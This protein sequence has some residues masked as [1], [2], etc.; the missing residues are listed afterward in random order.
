VT[1]L[2]LPGSA[3]HC[4]S[5]LPFS[6]FVLLLFAVISA[7]GMRFEFKHSFRP[8]FYLGRGGML[9]FWDFGGSTVATNDRIRLTPA[10]QSKVGWIWN[11]VP[12]E[13][14]AWEVVLEFEIGGG[15]ARGADGM[16]FWY[17]QE[18]KQ[19][20]IALGGPA[21][22]TGMALFFDTFDNDGLLDNPS[23]SLWLND[24]TRLYDPAIDGRNGD[25]GRCRSYVRDM[26]SKLRVN[27]SNG[28]ITVEID[29]GSG[30]W[31]PCISF[32]HT[33]PTGYYFG[34]S[35]ATGQLTDNHDIY[36]FTTYN[37][38]PW[39][40][41]LTR[42]YQNDPDY[43]AQSPEQAA[44]VE[45]EIPNIWKPN[46][47]LPQD[48]P[49]PYLPH[50]EQQDQQEFKAPTPLQPPAQQQY[51]PPIRQQEAPK[52]A[53]YQPPP[54]PSPPQAQHVPSQQ[55]VPQN[56]GSR[57]DK[58]ST[59]LDFLINKLDGVQKQQDNLALSLAQAVAKVNNLGLASPA[60][61][62]S[63]EIRAA[64]QTVKNIE[65]SVANLHQ[66]VQHDTDQLNK[67]VSEIRQHIS[68]E[69]SNTQDSS[70]R[71]LREL[72]QQVIALQNLVERGDRDQ[73]RALEEIKNNKEELKTVVQQSGSVGW[74]VYFAF[75]QVCFGVGFVLWKKARDEANK[76][77]L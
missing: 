60:P 12:A 53:Q 20:G 45:Q 40:H 8:P 74:W 51:Q 18:M 15:G 66:L 17:T 38:D 44:P 73:N 42:V 76:K 52:M 28:T 37:L 59:Q 2:I 33:L 34:F 10:Q 68:K 54:P 32:S 35:A 29:S 39:N 63:Q 61:D 3:M 4:N 6:L 27:N 62:T 75:F 50:Q 31:T 25:L 14:Q 55:D 47:N 41:R 77:F 49:N 5:A 70:I 13:M 24:G 58:I 9:P 21:R 57:E 36:S 67:A 46:N 23:I 64:L 1:F 48:Q 69:Q 7:H 26:R 16:A 19:E 72:Q 11:T 30:S 43:L 71:M 56:L 65:G 22:F